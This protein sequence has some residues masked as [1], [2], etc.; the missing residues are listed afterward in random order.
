M[1]KQRTYDSSLLQTCS[2]CNW[3]ARFDAST[4][5]RAHLAIHNEEPERSSDPVN[6][7]DHYNQHPM[8]CIDVLRVLLTPEEFDGFCRGNAIKYRWRAGAK[9]GESAERDLAKAAWYER[10]MTREVKPTPESR[11]EVTT[12]IPSDAAQDCDQW[13]RSIEAYE[14]LVA[15]KPFVVIARSENVKIEAPAN[16]G[17]RGVRGVYYSVEWD[18]RG[19]WTR[20]RESVARES[21]ASFE[22]A[23][24]KASEL[25]APQR[26]EAIALTADEY[27][28]VEAIEDR[29]EDDKVEPVATNPF[30]VINRMVQVN[31][32]V[33]EASAIRGAEGWEPTSKWFSSEAGKRMKGISTSLLLINKDVLKLG[34]LSGDDVTLLEQIQGGDLTGLQDP[35][36]TMRD[37]R[38]RMIAQ[39]NQ[40]RKSLA[41]RVSSTVR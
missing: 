24:Q 22:R 1:S 29:N 36:P 41:P 34:V 20:A 39:F 2:R 7:P 40:D 15:T 3:T 18:V 12:P 27:G 9:E 26:L 11:T 14:A 30:V 31:R 19:V 21:V 37:M 35:R 8:E 32:L 5:I 10:A 33:T 13:D 25:A 17:V 16:R 38:R 28:I 4:A 6:H 23:W